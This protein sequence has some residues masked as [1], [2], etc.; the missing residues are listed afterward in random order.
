MIIEKTYG[1]HG[2]QKTSPHLSGTHCQPGDYV[3]G[4][5]A[6]HEYAKFSKEFTAS[7]LWNFF[8]KGRE[9]R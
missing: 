9:E 8:K 2:S 4:G 5:K 6:A 7:F 1:F 3:L